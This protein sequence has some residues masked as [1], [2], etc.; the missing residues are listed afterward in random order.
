M[1]KR[2]KFFERCGIPLL[3]L[4]R[5][6]AEEANRIEQAL[7]IR[8][9]EMEHP[10]HNKNNEAAGCVNWQP[11]FD[12]IQSV[13]LFSAYGEANKSI[14][15]HFEKHMVLLYKQPLENCKKRCMEKTQRA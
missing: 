9:K 15:L 1:Q 12:I 13:K 8:C 6:K 4:R 7:R 14:C 3:R 2:I 10:K 5:M 11:F